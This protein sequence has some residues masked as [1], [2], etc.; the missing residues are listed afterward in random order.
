MVVCSY[1]KK[2]KYNDVR[3]SSL[4][5]N[6]NIPG[7]RPVIICQFTLVTRLLYNYKNIFHIFC[8]YNKSLFFVCTILFVGCGA[9]LAVF[10][11]KIDRNKK[12]FVF[13]RICKKRC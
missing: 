12:D 3:G 6:S 10:F 9:M 11:K 2:I 4:K 1:Q 5:Y 8:N 7:L 13:G